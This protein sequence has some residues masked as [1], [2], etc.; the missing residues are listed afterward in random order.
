MNRRTFIVAN[1]VGLG[2]VQSWQSDD[3]LEERGEQGAIE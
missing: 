3:R 2:L 1:P